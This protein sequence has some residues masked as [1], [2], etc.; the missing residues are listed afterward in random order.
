MMG[1]LAAN[2]R[3][4]EGI[5]GQSLYHYQSTDALSVVSASGYFDDAVDEYGLG[6]GD[7]VLVTAG[8]AKTEEIALFVATVTAGVV[9][10]EGLYYP[11]AIRFTAE[12]GLA[13][14]YLNGTGAVSVKG[15]VVTV[16]Q[17]VD[18]SV[19]LQTNEY[20]AIGAVYESGIA[21]DA[22]VWVVV[23]GKAQVLYKDSTA[24]TRGN[25]CISDAVDGR[26]SDIANLGDGLPAADIHFKEIG[27]VLESKDAGTNVLVYV[28]LHFN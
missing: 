23:S 22:P 27:H 12:G 16:S 4:I 20:D 14:R 8:S 2:M 5:P 24:A 28:N 19:V 6:T 1:Y 18:L 13:V 17:A 21:A 7:V 26:A 3:R 10:T 11:G 25:L 15:S 9:S